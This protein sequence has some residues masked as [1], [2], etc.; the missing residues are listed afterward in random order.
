[1]FK[2]NVYHHLVIDSGFGRAIINILTDIYN[3][4]TNIMVS[5]QDL[6]AKADEQLA[7]ITAETEVVEAV[8][9]VVDNQNAAIVD[10]KDQIA[11]LIAQ[12]S[13]TPADLQKLSDT[14][15][16]MQT[17]DTANAT[18]VAEAVAAG[19]PAEA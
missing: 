10:L 17:L 9:M 14:L 8:K 19:T 11:V 1:M 3:Q 18:K 7:R 2:I 5:I 15:D 6:Q 4:G 13:V 12:G 16:Q